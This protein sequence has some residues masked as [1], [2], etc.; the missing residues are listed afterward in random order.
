MNTPPLTIGDAK[1][2]AY[3]LL[4]DHFEN[5]GN[6]RH[7]IDGEIKN[8]FACLAICQYPAD[9]GYYLFYCDRDWNVLTDTYHNN[10]EGA[11]HQAE[12]EYE[13]SSSSWAFLEY[14]N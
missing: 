10:I 1:T 5:S 13:G 14:G 6:T 9:T 2:I 8:S 4:A 3:L 12:S 7:F 11:I